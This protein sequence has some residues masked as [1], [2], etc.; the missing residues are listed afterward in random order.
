MT[1]SLTPPAVEEIR[2]VENGK[3]DRRESKKPPVIERTII[4]THITAA[5]FTMRRNIDSAFLS[6]LRPIMIPMT[7]LHTDVIESI[8]IDGKCPDRA[9]NRVI[10][11]DPIRAG[12]GSFSFLKTRYPAV[13]NRYRHSIA[14]IS[15]I[16]LNGGQ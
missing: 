15:L 10:V 3:P 4:Q 11:I 8:E 14:H 9:K 12:R 2:A 1:I 7:T 16:I 6:N 13:P 5:G